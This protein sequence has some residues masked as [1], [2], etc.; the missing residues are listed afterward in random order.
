LSFLPKQETLPKVKG[1]EFFGHYAPAQEVGGDY[2][3][4]ISLPGNRI[5]I[6]IGD[7]AGKGVA[8]ALLMARVS[9]DARYTLLTE[10][11]PAAAMCKLNTLMQEAGM[12]D[13]FVTL[14][15][16]LLDPNRNEV[17]FVNAGHNPAVIFRHRSGKLE[18]VF[19]HKVGG[20]PLGVVEVCK[21]EV[22]AT[23]GLEPGDVCV[24]FSDGVTEAR[25]KQDKDFDLDGRLFATLRDGPMTAVAMG[26]RLVDA[27]KLHS[28]GCPQH[29]DI[30][31]VCFARTV[32]A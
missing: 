25:N 3:D 10:A 22:C 2:Y 21:Y 31:V 24:M 26:Q 8:A 16:A 28:L 29:D 15:I 13:K 12:L 11:G 9:S 4:L 1:Y 32:S 17:T 23:V 6:A 27:V 5:G 18:E 20:F 30:T 19:S 14:E 7:V